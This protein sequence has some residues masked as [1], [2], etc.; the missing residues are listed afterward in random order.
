[1]RIHFGIIA[2]LTTGCAVQSK[3]VFEEVS[4]DTVVYEDND[5]DGYYAYVDDGDTGTVFSAEFDCD[6][7]DPNVQPGATEVCDGIDNDCDGSVD[8]GFSS[9][10]VCGLGRI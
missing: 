8:E 5:N 3:S 6:D 10:N 9:T 7:S 4:T 2:L 1:M